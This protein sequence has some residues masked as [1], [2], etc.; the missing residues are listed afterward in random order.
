MARAT[1]ARRPC[2]SDLVL[3]ERATRLETLT[4]WGALLD[5]A[6]TLQDTTIAELFATDPT[7]GTRLSVEVAG[8]YLDYSKHRIDDEG[9]ERL[10]ALAEARD[11][12]GRLDAMFRGDIVNHTEQ[13]PA[14]HTALR[15]PRTES[16]LVDDHDVVPDVHAVLGQ[17]A[18][19]AER[20]RT[21]EWRGFTGRPI[22]N[23]VNIG[24]GGSDLGPRMATEALRMYA[25]RSLT[26]RFISNVDST[27]FF[28][29]VR[30]L[31]PAETLFI[32]ASKSFTTQ[33]TMANARVARGWCLAAL[34]DERAIA[35]HFVAVST[36]LEAVEAFGID[37]ANAFGFWDWV[38]GRYSLWSAIGLA[39]MV[40]I[41]PRHFAELLA[42]AREMDEHVR[43][44]PF[45]QNM[46]VLMGLL[47]VWYANGF[48]TESV[49]VMPYDEYLARL[50]DYLQQLTMESNGKRVTASGPTS[51][52]TGPIYWGAAGTNGQHSFFQ[53]LHQ[54]THLVPCDLI[55]FARS[56][57][58]PD[59]QH[60]LLIANM[61]AQAEALAF[62]T[63]DED[64]EE[65]RICPGNQPTSVILADELSPRTLG[66]LIALYEHIVFTQAVI[67]DI[68]PFDQFGV[69]LGKQLANRL[70]P[71]LRG[72]LTLEPHDSS[73][74][75][76]VARYRAM[77]ATAARP[78][79]AAQPLSSP[80]R[81]DRPW[82]RA[83]WHPRGDATSPAS[84]T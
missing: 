22:V 55:G 64:I 18:V 27:D 23:I 44:A 17:M 68:D 53:L 59:P 81:R 80:Q 66:A 10:R 67:W 24:I 42:G 39:T 7:R 5:H 15:A 62:G 4:E 3:A 33:E 11:L 75:A 32:V 1:G 38:G 14:L 45:D 76:L 63:G 20:I 71:K 52:A 31:D 43:T 57:H 78:V 29:A 58:E 69:E 50:P 30:D 54:G 74:S 26:V 82:Q 84:R 37:P 60:D 28:E 70:L 19:F 65:A 49:G 47:G 35:R 48:G 9:L 72:E 13:R 25:D 83:P 21:R 46:P 36:N 61:F 12:R 77:R 8:L 51:H 6:S 73:T 34:R 56:A 16:V 41:G 2:G 79:T 40:A